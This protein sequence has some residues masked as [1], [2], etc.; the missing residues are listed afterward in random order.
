[1]QYI[2]ETFYI[3]TYNILSV[4]IYR[5]SHAPQ[6]PYFG[7]NYDYRELHETCGDNIDF[8][9][10]QFYNQGNE[11]YNTYQNMY[12][13]TTAWAT[14]SN[15]NAWKSIVGLEKIV[16]GK[17]TPGGCGATVHEM[18][19]TAIKSLIQTAITNN[20]KPAGFMV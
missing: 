1:M 7:T 15:I 14:G 9:N 4:H 5:I 20:N 13:A 12:V 2:T 6:A 3:T 17:C 8:H 16:I 19:G 11:R 18:T 10:V